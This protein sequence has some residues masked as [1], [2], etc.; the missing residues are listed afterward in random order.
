MADR[1]DEQQADVDGAE[2]RGLECRKCGCRDLR[3]IYTRSGRGGH[4]VRRRECRHCGQRL[5]TWERPVG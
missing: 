4:I 1:R 3:V 5:V 2:P